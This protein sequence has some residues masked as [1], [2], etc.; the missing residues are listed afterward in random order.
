MNWLPKRKV[1]IP[2]DFSDQSYSA[3]D[4]ALSMV[5][6]PRAI[7]VIHVLPILTDYEAGLMWTGLNDESRSQQPLE[8]MRKHLEAPKYSGIETVV[9]FGDAG[10]QIVDYAEELGADLI[11]LP[12]HGRTGLSRLLIGSVAERVVRLAHC[13][14]LVLK[15]PLKAKA[16]AAAEAAKSAPAPAPSPAP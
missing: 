12:S 1:I 3:V 11:I 8:T 10:T 7:H 16:H 9:L 13:P 2:V 14:V 6:S 4:T 5:E 15:A